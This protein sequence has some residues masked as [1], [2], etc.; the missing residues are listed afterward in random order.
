MLRHG[1]ALELPW[2]YLSTVFDGNGVHSA[3]GCGTGLFL[4]ADPLPALS[5]RQGEGVGAL[6]YDLMG[7]ESI[8]NRQDYSFRSCY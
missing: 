4:L 7:K 6:A 3:I 1:R 2:Q 8:G 5:G